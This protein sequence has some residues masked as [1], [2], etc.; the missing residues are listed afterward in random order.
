MVIMS[1]ALVSE[2]ISVL[3]KTV[4]FAL[5]ILLSEIHFITMAFQNR[6]KIVSLVIKMAD[7]K[8]L[9]LPN[10]SNSCDKILP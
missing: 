8:T 3:F 4:L 1:M 2:N 10:L 5:G 7:F 9:G 6:A